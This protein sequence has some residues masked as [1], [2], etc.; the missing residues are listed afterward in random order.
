MNAK[1]LPSLACISM[2]A[3]G[4]TNTA[5]HAADAVK[6]VATMVADVALVTPTARDPLKW[7]F[8]HTSIWNTPI[9][10]SAKYV[11]A[12]LPA[13]PRNNIWAGMPQI[14]EEI[15]VLKP[16]APVTEVKLSTA[17]WSGTDRCAATGGTLFWAPM[18]ANFVIPNGRGNNSAVFMASDQRTLIHTQPFA[19]CT[20]GGYATSWATFTTVDLYGDG[21]L[22]SHGASKL[23]AIGGSIRLGEL[24]PGAQPPRHALKIDVD[25]RVVL[26]ACKVKTDCYRWP[27]VSADSYAVGAYGTLGTNVP[28]AMRMGTL[29][30]LP[31]TVDINKLGL[32]T[33]PGIMIAWTLQNYGAYI[34]DDSSGAN[35]VLNAET[36]PDGSKRDEFKRDWGYD[37]QAVVR[38]NTPWVRDLQRLVPLLAAVDNNTEATP[39]GGGAPRQTVAPALAAPK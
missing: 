24:R 11:A 3:L 22:G 5:A 1:R 13:T 25:A 37:L 6:T 10:A 31:S 9:G 39:G 4:L 33:K 29:L 17:G 19:R 36:G 32:E 2:A 28:F 12:N 8:A 23:S 21:R 26:Y 38:D 27:A 35:F 16:T 34:V 7:P 15:I 30:A 18:P 20:A 14:D